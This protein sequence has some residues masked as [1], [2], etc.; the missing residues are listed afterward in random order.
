[1][2]TVL[3]P[4]HSVLPLRFVE[5]LA[6]N[7]VFLNQTPEAFAAVEKMLDAQELEFERGWKLSLENDGI[8]IRNLL[9]SLLLEK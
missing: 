7:D 4:L 3:Q 8:K 1:M 6:L 5:A 9:F 2:R